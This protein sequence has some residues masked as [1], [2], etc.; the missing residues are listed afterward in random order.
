MTE[1]LLIH[2]AFVS[3]K[4]AGG[5]RHLELGRRL[6]ESGIRLTVV[7][8]SLSYL[9]G[10][11]VSKIEGDKE[12]GVRVIRVPTYAALHRSFFH[13]V[14]SFLSFMTCAFFRGLFV[15]K[16]DLVWGTTPPIFQA[17]SACLIAKLKR[18]PFLLEVRDLWPEFAIEMGVLKNG[19]AIFIARYVEKFLYRSAAHIVVNSPAYKEYLVEKGVASDQ[20]SI[21]PNGVESS[22]FDPNEKGREIRKELG[23][24]GKFVVTYAGA[25]GMANDIET[26]LDAAR[27][28]LG[29]RGIH[30]MILGDG[31]ERANLEKKSTELGLTNVTWLG[32]RPKDEVARYLGASDACVAILM[33]I[34][35]FK[36]TYPNKVFDYMAAGRPTILVIDGVVR[37]VVEAADGGIF[38]PPGNSTALSQAIM[39]VASNPEWSRAA[40]L[41]ARKY[42]CQHFERK[43]QSE[44]FCKLIKRIQ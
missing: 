26:L 4:E 23:I 28:I 8:S 6:R 32:A 21:I 20:I 17:V 18:V 41:R 19:F 24:D 16:V 33:N 31:K 10:K 34:P 3:G 44:E 36:T 30:I 27:Q 2:Q 35:M 22:M 25:I 11:R 9:S 42:V 37:S 1:I 15:R 38:V 40:G 12:T 29:E 7:A 13:R 14:L 43:K 5:T 39:K